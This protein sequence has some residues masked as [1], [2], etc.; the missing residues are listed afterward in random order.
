M[1]D[2]KRFYIKFTTIYGTYVDILNQKLLKL[3]LF[4]QFSI[5][6]RFQWGTILDCQLTCYRQVLSKRLKMSSSSQFVVCLQGWLA[7]VSCFLLTFYYCKRFCFKHLICSVCCMCKHIEY[8]IPMCVT[9]LYFRHDFLIQHTL[10][11]NIAS[12]AF[13]F[14]WPL[15]IH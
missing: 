2:V 7:L 11:K 14:D 10:K 3:S 6:A 12:V 9:F 15:Q 5:I 1:L 13:F 8:R 4:S